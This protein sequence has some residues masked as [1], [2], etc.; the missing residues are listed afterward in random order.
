MNF[1]I[2]VH[3]MKKKTEIENKLLFDIN[4]KLI[5]YKNDIK[6]IYENYTI[7][8]DGLDYD[9]NTDTSGNKFQNINFNY[10]NDLLVDD[11]NNFIKKLFEYPETLYSIFMFFYSKRKDYMGIN[12]TG[13][14]D[15]KMETGLSFRKSIDKIN[16]ENVNNSELKKII[17]SKYKN[18]IDNV[19]IY[20]I[21][22]KLFP[23][24]EYLIKN[25]YENYFIVGNLHTKKF[26]ILLEKK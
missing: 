23:W 11:K 26:E 20:K 24:D 2:N 19:I 4:K 6:I 14:V 12:L 8:C 17:F 9:I 13:L 21:N 18:N 3:E 1:Q 22:S 10:L 5:E 25:K 16:P 15:G 7:D